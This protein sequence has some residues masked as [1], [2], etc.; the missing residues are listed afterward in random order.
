MACFT[1][2]FSRIHRGLPYHLAFAFNYTNL[3]TG[4][5]CSLARSAFR[6]IDRFV[7]SS[8]V[9][10]SLYS[11]YFDLDPGRFDVLLWGIGKPV[12][13]EAAPRIVEGDY[14]CAL[15]GEGRDYETL[16]NTA[17]LTPGIKY[18]VVARPYSIAGMVVPENVELMVNIPM[19]TC[20]TLLMQSR[21]LLVSLRDT[22][23]PCGHVTLVAG[24][25]LRKALI[26]TDSRGI[27][28]YVKD[29]E[30]AIVV[31]PKDPKAMAEAVELLIEDPALADSLGA[32]G[33]EFA[34]ANCSESST[35]RYFSNLLQELYR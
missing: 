14:V 7:V 19:Q 10:R 28:D 12:V 25:H 3:P 32:R 35:I 30:N 16:F 15:G 31:P 24:M 26:T 20:W 4:M 2:E 5:R 33:E 34:Q 6:G 27:A 22:N 9:E 29:R 21:M 17:R 8:T 1:E 11:E 23:V 13:P 18:V